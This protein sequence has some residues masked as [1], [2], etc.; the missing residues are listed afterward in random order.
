MHVGEEAAEAIAAAAAGL[1]LASTAS[2][3]RTC[4]MDGKKKEK[5]E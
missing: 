2:K 4:T 3:L 5:E 1:L